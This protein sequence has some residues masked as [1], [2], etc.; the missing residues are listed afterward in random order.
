[1]ICP[2][3]VGKPTMLTSGRKRFLRD[4]E[5]YLGILHTYLDNS[6]KLERSSDLPKTVARY[7]ETHM[8]CNVGIYSCIF[9]SGN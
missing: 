6:L 2:L 1:M 4:V 5:V 3:V 8:R 9:T 7:S